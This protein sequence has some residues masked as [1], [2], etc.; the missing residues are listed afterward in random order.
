MVNAAASVAIVL[1]FQQDVRFS[2]LVACD[3]P[4]H[5]VPKKGDDYSVLKLH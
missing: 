4:L 1:Y 2:A 3:S 5:S